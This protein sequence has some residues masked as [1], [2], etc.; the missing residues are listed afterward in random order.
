MT[1]AN[2]LL[3]VQLNVT[4]LATTEA[5]Y[6]GIL[7]IP[8]QRA[9]TAAGA[10]AHL[11]LAAN[12]MELVFV[13]EADVIAAHPLLTDRL[14]DYP[15]GVGITFHFQVTEIEAIYDAVREEGLAILYPLEEKPYGMKEFWCFD[16]DGYLVVLEEPAVQV[17]PDKH[18]H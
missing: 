6:A 17:T 14:G 3:S 4:D 16:P 15:K 5:F 2:P 12:G 13:E 7:E 10:P 18:L 11:L 1:G 8:V 9:L